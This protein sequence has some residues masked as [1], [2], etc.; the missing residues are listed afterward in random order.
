MLRK[1]NDRLTVYIFKTYF[2][3]VLL[4][5]INKVDYQFSHSQVS[6]NSQFR[7]SF[8]VYQLDIYC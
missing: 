7:N 3:K 2:F 8:A 1:T 4:S 5:A 6:H